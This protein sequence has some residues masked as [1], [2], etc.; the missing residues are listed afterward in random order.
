MQ[1]RS[2]LRQ[3]VFG[4]WL[5]AGL[6]LVLVVAAALASAGLFME[7]TGARTTVVAGERPALVSAQ[8]ASTTGLTSSASGLTSSASAHTTA[9]GAE[10]SSA[11]E[12][13]NPEIDPT[14]DPTEPPESLPARAGPSPAAEGVARADATPSPSATDEP[15]PAAAPSPSP[16]AVAEAAPSPAPFARQMP[17]F[18]PSGAPRAAAD[19]PIVMYHHVGPLPPNPDQIRR[20]LTVPPEVFERTL[21]QLSE[22][23]VATVTMAELFAHFAGGPELPKRTAILTFDDGYDDVYD[24][25]FQALRQRGM[26]GTF[27]ITTDFVERPGYLSWAQI[28]EM[29]DAGME[30]AAHSLNHPDFRR[31]GPAELNRQLAQPKAI[32]EDHIGRPVRFVAYPSGMYS[33][34]VMVA[35]KA[36]GYEAAVTV[37][38]GT[39]HVPGMAFELRRVRAHGADSVAEIVARMT[40][41][42]WR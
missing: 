15:V 10:R 13:E 35:T 1:P 27:F 38:H 2:T 20:D 40:P 25:A 41:P 36:A 22:K 29:A 30:I 9:E 4:S 31:L 3:L 8:T 42:S 5:V 16:E 19:L 39:H 33:P 26:V 11:D 37:I 21:D 24:Y 6:V 23:G 32:L 28:Q 14:A 7:L 12:A 18:G 34:A 17:E